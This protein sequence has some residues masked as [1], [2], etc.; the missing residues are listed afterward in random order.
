MTKN[1]ETVYTTHYTLPPEKAPEIVGPH[2]GPTHPRAGTWCVYLWASKQDHL[3]FYLGI[4][5]EFQAYELI[6]KNDTGRFTVHQTY[7]N[8]LKADFL[9]LLVHK[10]LDH[11][12]ALSMCHYLY[13][14]LTNLEEPSNKGA[15]FTQKAP[16][17]IPKECEEY[18]VTRP[19]LELPPSTQEQL[20]R[21]LYYKQDLHKRLRQQKQNVEYYKKYK[22][23]REEARLLLEQPNT[24]AEDLPRPPVR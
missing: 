23:E 8:L 7:R 3:P 2:T 22:K 18:T 5:T 1:R 6:H 21:R 20:A 11:N 12:H 14:H 13:H 15:L 9:C 17:F 10:Y 16:T 4:G 19:F 24:K